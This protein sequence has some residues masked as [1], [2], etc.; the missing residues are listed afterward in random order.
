MNAAVLNEISTPIGGVLPEY[1]AKV[2]PKVEPILKRV[3]KPRTG[4]TTDHVLVELQL[5]KW[6]LWVIGNFDAVVTTCI[7]VRPLHKVLWVP[8]I[9]G[10]NMDSWLDDWLKVQDAFAKENE[11]IAIEFAGRKGWQRELRNRDYKPMWVILRKE[12]T[13]E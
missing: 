2:W 13:Y 10:N 7:Q 6:Q 9:A 8:F 12:L 4:Y 5:R 1:V 11:C 3:V